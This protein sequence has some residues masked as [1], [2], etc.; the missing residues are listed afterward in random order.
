[1]KTHVLFLQ[2]AGRGAYEADSRLVANLRHLLGLEYDNH[3][4]MMEDEDNPDYSTWKQ[5]IESELATLDGDVILTGHSLG[6]SIL[7]KYLAESDVEKTISGYFLL[8]LHF[9]VATAGD[10]KAMRLLL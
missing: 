6:A 8:L 10:M 7:I 1:M 5:Q 3:Y 4:P 2:G 9:G